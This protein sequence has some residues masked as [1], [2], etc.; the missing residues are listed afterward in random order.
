M[1]SHSRNGKDLL[2][3]QRRAAKRAA[4]REAG[5][6]RQQQ[7]LAN[8]ASRSSAPELPLPSAFHRYHE[9][10]NADGPASSV[11]QSS[12]NNGLSAPGSAVDHPSVLGDQ[13]AA[14]YTLSPAALEKIRRSGEQQQVAGATSSIKLSRAIELRPTSDLCATGFSDPASHGSAAGA[15]PPV[16]YSLS[17]DALERL[18]R[19]REP[20][21]DAQK[22]GRDGPLNLQPSGSPR[23][24]EIHGHSHTSSGQVHDYLKHPSGLVAP[25]Y[26]RLAERPHVSHEN[27]PSPSGL[28]PANPSKHVQDPLYDAG[29]RWMNSQRRTSPTRAIHT[30]SDQAQPDPTTPPATGPLQGS[31]IQHP[32]AQEQHHVQLQPPLQSNHHHYAQHPRQNGSQFNPP[33]PRNRRLRYRGGRSNPNSSTAPLDQLPPNPQ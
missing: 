19:A 4:A 1:P 29:V 32:T 33:Y 5:R 28:Y 26:Q 9:L 18:C 22:L 12:S 24:R 3:E 8:L 7:Q 27:S 17:S 23:P 16:G 11:R 21:S 30:T 20:Q 25:V 13:P 31:Q 2:F 15:Y 6:I 14:G 10:P